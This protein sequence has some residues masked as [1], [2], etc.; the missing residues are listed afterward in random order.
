[1][2]KIILSIIFVIPFL[3][4]N[5][6]YAGKGAGGELLY[7]WI[8]DST[9]RFLFRYYRDCSDP[10]T[11]TNMPLCLYNSCTG[12]AM[13]LTM[14]KFPGMPPDTVFPN[15]CNVKSQCDSPASTLNGF[16]GQWYSVLATLPARCN[17]WRIFTYY[18]TRTASN[19]LLNAATIPLYVETRFNNQAAQGNSSPYFTAKPV[20]SY[21]LNVPA[22]YNYGA[23]D[24]NG[25]SLVYEV[26][27]PLTGPTGMSCS[28]SALTA[29]FATGA[30]A[31]FSIPTNPFQTQNTFNLN[32]LSGAM[33][34]TPK[35]G[36]TSVL[37]IRVKEYRN[38]VL[39]GS[40]MRDI[41][42]NV[43]GSTT[44][45]SSVED[46][47]AAVKVYPN[48]GNGIFT[49]TGLARE[50]YRIEIVNT[51][52]QIVYKTSD[53]PVTGQLSV[54]TTL[55]AGLYYL[56]LTDNNTHQQTIKLTIAE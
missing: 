51:F 10:N 30:P 1:M 20:S 4:S 11:P 45:V 17:S 50:K 56:K 25:D 33:T 37:T 13:T 36:G 24:P 6:S 35:Q 23:V 39:I 8:S 29:T 5:T 44:D 32:I 27:N 14:A 16:K 22:S 52:G 28:D 21:C 7:E 49:I 42:I 43:P 55:A 53:T 15:M 40:I 47:N 2:K 34:F 48:P 18:N 46:N 19:N 54:H 3:F 31:A 12:T 26:I 41:T 9:Y 38:S